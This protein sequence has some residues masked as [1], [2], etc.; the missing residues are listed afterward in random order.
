MGMGEGAVGMSCY[1]FILFLLGNDLHALKD[2]SDVAS[3]W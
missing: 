2:E 3:G 1:G